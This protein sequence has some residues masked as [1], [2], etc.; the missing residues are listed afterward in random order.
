M[1]SNVWSPRSSVVDVA[2][3]ELELRV[4]RRRGLNHLRRQVDSNTHRRLERGEQIALAAADL[5]DRRSLWDVL[6]VDL[7]EPTMVVAAPSGIATPRG[8]V[9]ILAP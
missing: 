6:P 9:P 8:R 4:A 7:F 2:N 3:D 1:K 5:K